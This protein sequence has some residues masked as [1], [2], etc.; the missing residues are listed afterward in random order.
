VNGWMKCASSI[1]RSVSRLSGS[2]VRLEHTPRPLWKSSHRPRTTTW[3]GQRRPP[4]EPLAL[5]PE[6]A[7]WYLHAMP[8]R[9]AGIH[10]ADL[11]PGDRGAAGYDWCG[12]RIHRIRSAEHAWFERAYER[13]WQEFGARA[14][15]EERAVIEGRLRWRPSEPVGGHA[16]PLRA[17]RDRRRRGSDRRPRSHR[18]RPTR[19]RAL[20]PGPRSSCTSR[21]PG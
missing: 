8:E 19:G 18:D 7:P 1:R 4:E 2:M 15:M 21:T 3:R 6:P 5:A 9:L 10:V 20:R 16:L 17:R 14:E 11:A 12:K 13:L